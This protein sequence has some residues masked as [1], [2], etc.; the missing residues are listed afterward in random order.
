MS[1]RLV[2]AIM[3]V[4]GCYSGACGVSGTPI[5][6]PPAPPELSVEEPIGE[7][8][9]HVGPPAAPA[10]PSASSEATSSAPASVGP[11]AV[12]AIPP[13][14]PPAAVLGRNTAEVEH[15]RALLRTNGRW[16]HYAEGLSVLFD[17][18]IAVRL[19]LAPCELGEPGLPDLVAAGFDVTVARVS[20]AV[21]ATVVDGIPGAHVEGRA[22]YCFVYRTRGS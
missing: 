21:D 6:T 5:P 11:S 22:H 20:G 4:L 2:R 18:G 13:A 10:R 12:L 15:G 8:V 1:A 14:I 19:R 3:V 17:H 16:R 9:E 7:P